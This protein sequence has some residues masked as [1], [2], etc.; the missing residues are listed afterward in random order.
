MVGVMVEKLELEKDVVMV[1]VM[2]EKSAV[3]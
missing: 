2:V 1:G 3:E